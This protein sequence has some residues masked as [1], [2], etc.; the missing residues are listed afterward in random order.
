[1]FLKDSVSHIYL[2]MLRNKAF[3]LFA[4][5]Q[6]ACSETSNARR[7]QPLTRYVYVM[8]LAGLVSQWMHWPGFSLNVAAVSSSARH[9]C[10]VKTC[11]G[12]YTGRKCGEMGSD[13]AIYRPPSRTKPPHSQFMDFNVV[14]VCI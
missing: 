11:T 1:L 8:N 7:K 4:L 12:I 3:V 6:L 9:L 10:V 5:R 2:V 14:T 13:N